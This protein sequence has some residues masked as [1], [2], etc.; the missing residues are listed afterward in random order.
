MV[1][2]ITVTLFMFTGSIKA[3]GPAYRNSS[4]DNPEQKKVGWQPAILINGSNL[5]NG[6]EFYT[7]KAWCSV[8]KVNPKGNSASTESFDPHHHTVIP[9]MYISQEV[10]FVK[11]VNTN[12][13]AVRVSYQESD[14]SLVVNI[15]LPPSTTIK[16]ACDTKD[17]N[18]SKLVIKTLPDKADEEKQKNHLRSSLAVTKIQ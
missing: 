2:I 17:D 9:D 15:L 5:Q 18:L 12:N 10:D 11:L 14:F 6:V 4:S 16:G 13:Y 1:G 7:Q 8:K 3:Q